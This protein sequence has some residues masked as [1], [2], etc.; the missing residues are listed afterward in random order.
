MRLFGLI[1]KPLGHSFSKRYFTDKFRLEKINDARYEL[2]ELESISELTDI[3]KKA[4]LQGLNVTIPYKEQVQPFLD[5][6]DGSAEKIG[7][8]NVIRIDKNGRKTGYNSDYYGF[9]YALKDWLPDMHRLKAL[10]LGTGGSSHAVRAVLEDLMIPHRMVSRSA[11]KGLTY[12]QLKRDT[13][14]TAAHKLIINATPLGMS[15]NT[16]SYPD[17]PYDQLTPEHRLFDLVYNPELTEFSAS[18]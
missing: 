3:F 6:L 11:D 13:K 17:I 18:G 12:S 8:V 14:I 4:G 5:E 10:I 1:G 2:F 9:L 16:K 15:P 7:A